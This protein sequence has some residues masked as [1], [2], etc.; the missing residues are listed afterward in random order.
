[1]RDGERFEASV[2][3]PKWDQD[4]PPSDAELEQK[5]HRL[6]GDLIPQARREALIRMLWRLETVTDVSDIVAYLL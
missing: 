3:G 2:S 5:F 4:A 6:V 1:M